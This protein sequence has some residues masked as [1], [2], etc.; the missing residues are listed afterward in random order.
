MH[1]RRKWQLQYSCLENPR[2]RGAWW[3]AVYR[4][5]Q[6]WTR[7]KRLS[8]SSCF[9]L[10]WD[11]PSTFK[12]QRK[13]RA[14]ASSKG[15]T[16]EDHSK[17][18]SGLVQVCTLR[19]PPPKPQRPSVKVQPRPSLLWVAAISLALPAPQL[20]GTLCQPGPPVQGYLQT[21]TPRSSQSAPPGE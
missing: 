16:A 4:V 7:L 2:D 13:R 19:S 11:A 17:G 20:W 8:S 5:T 21:G 15:L 9:S 6:S 18:R 12:T 1:E 10:T 14:A 3:A